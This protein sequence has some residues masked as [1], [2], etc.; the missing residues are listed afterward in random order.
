VAVH[1]GVR[2]PG[3]LSRVIGRFDP[4]SLFTGGQLG[5]WYDPSDLSSMFQDSAGTTPAAVDSPVGKLNDKS[6]NGYHLTQGT[7]SAR[8]VLRFGGGF[9]YLEFD[10]VDDALAASGTALALF[11]NVTAGSL[12]AAASVATLVQPQTRILSW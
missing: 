4:L 8:P 11:Q 6:G 5:A 9:Y 3:H 7:S 2:G 10:G 12:F 1:V